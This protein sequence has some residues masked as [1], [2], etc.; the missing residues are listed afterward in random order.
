MQQGNIV[1]VDEAHNLVDAINEM[2]STQLTLRQV[3]AEAHSRECTP[4][5]V[6]VL[7]MTLCACRA[8]IHTHTQLTQA[9]SQLDQYR[10]RYQNRLKAKNLSYIR[11]ILVIVRAFIKLLQNPHAWPASASAGAAGHAVA[12]TSSS[13]ALP[14]FTH[15]ATQESEEKTQISTS[16]DFLFATKIDNMNLFKIEKY[17]QRSEIVK[18]VT[19]LRYA[20]GCICSSS[21]LL[22]ATLYALVPCVRVVL[23]GVVCHRS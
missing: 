2:Y 14:A 8:F 20:Q 22:M 3:L 13:L 18:K 19:H 12:A 10:A 5:M 1:V 6:D 16:N 15:H 17:I 21:C 11:Q 7:T 23:R 4:L 9:E